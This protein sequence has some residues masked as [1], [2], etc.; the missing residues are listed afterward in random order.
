MGGCR[1]YNVR[2]SFESVLH[3]TRRDRRIVGCRPRHGIR[4][5]RLER[6]IG[7][8]Q[9]E[10]PLYLGEGCIETRGIGERRGDR[11]CRSSTLL[12]RPPLPLL[13]R[14]DPPVGETR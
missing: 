3:T 8:I 13:R 10:R 6:G 5:P 1:G 9:R 2:G 7:G 12:V 14:L 4:D 11:R